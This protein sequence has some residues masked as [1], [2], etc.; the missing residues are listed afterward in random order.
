MNTDAIS[1]NHVANRKPSPRHSQEVSE[2]RSKGDAN[3]AHDHA[4]IISS[5]LPPAPIKADLRAAQFEAANDPKKKFTI[6]HALVQAKITRSLQVLDWLGQRYDI[7][8]EVRVAK[9]EAAKL[10]QASTVSQLRTVEGQVALRYWEA[11]GKVLPEWL[12]FQGRMTSTHQNHASDPFN[13]ALNYGYGFLEAECRMAI[14]SVGLEPAVGF[15]HDFSDYQTKE[16]L[17]YDLQEPFRWLVDLS[18]V[19]AF[20][21][22]TLDLHDFYFTGDDYRYRF[23]AEAKQRFIGMLRERFNDGVLYKGRVL[24]WDTVIE[25]KANELGRFLTGKTSSLDF[26][27][28]APNLD[29]QDDQVLRAKILTLTASHANMLGIGKSTLHYIKKR[30]TRQ[31]SFTVYSKT[32]RKLSQRQ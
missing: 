17:A 32:R 15:L 21:S 31:P 25:Q 30:A 4:S 24:K 26:A 10:G 2:P 9:R 19:H 13:A 5:I 8:R 7:Q 11:F 28:P 16:S 29:R 12:D 23:E 22:G 1:K 20:E 3:K 18:V 6:A 27:E 14:N